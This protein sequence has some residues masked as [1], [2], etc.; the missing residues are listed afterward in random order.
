MRLFLPLALSLIGCD[1]ET[2]DTATAQ[3]TADD[4]LIVDF[5][6]TAGRFA[7]ALDE[8][9]APITVENFLVYVDAGFYDGADEQGATIFHRVIDDFVV[10][11][12]GLLADGSQ[13]TTERPIAL[14]SDNGRSNLRGTIAM[15]RTEAP[16]SATSQFFVNL[17]DNDPLD[18]RDDQ[19]PGYAV[20]GEVIEGMDVIDQIAGLETDDMSRPTE[21]VSVTAASRR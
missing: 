21:D 18:Y 17:I 8:A 2:A 10:Q 15:A 12:G 1:S 16:D 19:N 7:V 3:E 5:E 20:F 11:G 13:K 4:R 6:T 9:S 14:E